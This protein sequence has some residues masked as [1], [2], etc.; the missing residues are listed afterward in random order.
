MF[1]VG[2]HNMVA[3]FALVNHMVLMVVLVLT[4]G[5]VTAGRY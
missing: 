2:F 4:I 5:I 3:I 1:L